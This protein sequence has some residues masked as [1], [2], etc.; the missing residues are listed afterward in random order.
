MWLRWLLAAFHLVALGIGFAAVLARR[1]ALHGPLDDEGLRRVFFADNLWA[2]AAVLWLATGLVRAFTAL[3]KG[4][5]YYLSNVAFLTKMGLFVLVLVLEAW[6]MTTL[7]RWR[8]RRRR[9]E[10]LDTSRA[11]TLAVISQVQALLVVAMVFAA[12]AMARGLGSLG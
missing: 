6:P 2:V 1:R 3:E 9:G 10:P 11:N 7:I 4:S 5:S 12:T 8:I